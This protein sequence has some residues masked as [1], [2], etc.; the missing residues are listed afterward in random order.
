MQSMKQ[1]HHQDELGYTKHRHLA[2]VMAV[3]AQMLHYSPWHH[4]SQHQST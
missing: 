4:A 3:L 1:R 2:N